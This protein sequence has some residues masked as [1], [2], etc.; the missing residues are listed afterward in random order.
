VPPLKK[1]ALVGLSLLLLVA[2]VGGGAAVISL[3]HDGSGDLCRSKVV[4]TPH[5]HGSATKPKNLAEG[6]Q[7]RACSL[8]TKASRS[9]LPARGF[10]FDLSEAPLE[11][12]PGLVDS[13]SPAYWEGGTLM[14][15]NSAWAET[16][17][18]SGDS[19]ESLADPVQVELPS[20]SRP[21]IVWM[22]AIWRDPV[23]S[24]LFGWYHFEPADL[25]CQTAPIIGAAI[26]YDGGLSWRDQG[27]VIENGYGADCGYANG[28]FSGGAGD[29]SV[30]LGVNRRY[31]YFLFTNYAG[32][33]DQ[34]GIGIARS[35]LED[36]GQPGT[37]FKYYGNGWNQ[38]GVGGKAQALLPSTTGWKGPFVESFWGPS[39]HWNP[40]LGSYVALLNH[41][42]GEDWDQEGIYITFS[43]DLLR[44]TPPTKLL[45][46][47]YWYPQVVG[48]GPDE[49]DSLAGQSAR[50]Y[51]GGISTFILEFKQIGTAAGQ[52]LGNATWIRRD[53]FFTG[54]ADNPVVL[55]KWRVR[56]LDLFRRYVH[57]PNARIAIDGL[58]DGRRPKIWPI[59]IQDD[60]P[61]AGRDPG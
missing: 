4:R 6:L 22:E 48:M 45:D 50:L 10:N 53:Q 12:F 60:D 15:V 2:A 31:L 52:S 47:N 7:R 3:P 49:T 43:Q 57:D 51:V 36:K 30:V 28:Y 42:E 13:N 27:F 44:W 40:Y 16:Y 5:R 9:S 29:F 33:L 58:R 25:I 17:R 23:T 59:S 18:S 39:V 38:P 32:P 19:P 24:L 34:Q 56:Q 14:V 37:V 54:K 21:G 26:S 35:A 55:G 8:R 1:T 20:L 41:T 46:T 11:Q 61:G